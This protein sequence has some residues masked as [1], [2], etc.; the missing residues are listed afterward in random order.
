MPGITYSLGRGRPCFRREAHGIFSLKLY[1]PSECRAVFAQVA[2]I[3]SWDPA[4]VAGSDGA[5]VD[6]TVRAAWYV[7]R[8]KAPTLH[9]EFESKILSVVRR[10]LR[11]IWGCDLANCEGTHLVRYR[12]GGY[13]LPHKDAE[14]GRYEDRFFTVLCYLNDDF[15][16]GNTSFPSLGYSAKPIA[17]RALVF[18]SR[19]T[20]CAESVTSGEKF[21]FLS[22]L[23]GP[24][25]VRWL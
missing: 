17:G 12:A 20:H 4:A 25:P 10:F 2:A 5:L 6:T 11:Q 23:S 8:N 14:D 1:E 18:P 19:F 15:H 24:A 22:W 21:V 9:H 3:D 13:F 7:S 16:G